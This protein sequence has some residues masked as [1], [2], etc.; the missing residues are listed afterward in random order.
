MKTKKPNNQ[1]VTAAYRV[2]AEVHREDHGVPIVE[3]VLSNCITSEP[4]TIRGTIRQK[5]GQVI[6]FIHP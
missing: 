3:T 5:I 1:K 4:M 6:I 2:M